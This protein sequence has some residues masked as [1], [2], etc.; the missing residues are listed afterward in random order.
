MRGLEKIFSPMVVSNLTDSEVQA[1]ASDPPT[2]KRQRDFLAD[3]VAMLEEG[4]SILREVTRQ[5]VL[6]N[7]GAKTTALC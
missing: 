6:L 1:L 5:Y 3:E 4:Q 2:A 7:L